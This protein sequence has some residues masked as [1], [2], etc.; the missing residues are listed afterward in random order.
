MGPCRSSSVIPEHHRVSDH[1]HWNLA[2]TVPSAPVEP[3][4]NL[5]FSAPGPVFLLKKA[6]PGWS[7][8]LCV[9]ISFTGA[10]GIDTLGR[11]EI[12]HVAD[13]STCDSAN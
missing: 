2:M 5:G 6:F 8:H 13:A 9:H 4:A 12:A 10:G 7:L 3:P 1:S 11:G